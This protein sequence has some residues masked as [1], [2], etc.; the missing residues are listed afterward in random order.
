MNI[1]KGIWNFIRKFMKS[2][3]INKNGTDWPRHGRGCY[4]SGQ[5]ANRLALPYCG[6][7]M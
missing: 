4:A 1:I 7:N 2:L 6:M 5:E 3:R